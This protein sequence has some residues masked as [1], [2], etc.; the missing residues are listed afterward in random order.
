MKQKLHFFVFSRFLSSFSTGKIIYGLEDINLPK[1]I[2]KYHFPRLCFIEGRWSATQRLGSQPSSFLC[3]KWLWLCSQA[4]GCA[5]SRRDEAQPRKNDVLCS[6][7]NSS[8]IGAMRM[9]WIGV[10]MMLTFMF[11]VAHPVAKCFDPN[12]SDGDMM[13][14]YTPLHHTTLHYTTL[15]W[16]TLHHK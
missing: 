1:K 3:D 5:S 15:H 14:W 16:M 10:S 7:V 11:I 8:E 12:I 2:K 13:T 6:L 4:L 9:I